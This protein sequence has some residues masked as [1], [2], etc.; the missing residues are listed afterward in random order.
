M[1]QLSIMSAEAKRAE[2]DRREKEREAFLRKIEAERPARVETLISQVFNF[3]KNKIEEAKYGFCQVA[4]TYDEI[5]LWK[6]WNDDELR[7]AAAEVVNLLR[8]AGYE[9]RDFY[10]Y[11]KAWKTRSGKF[12]YIYISW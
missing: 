12:G 3:A 1:I 9:V 8:I 6:P 7:E 11:S 4:I 2:T 5:F 10:E